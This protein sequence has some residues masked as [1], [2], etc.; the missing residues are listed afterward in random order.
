MWKLP[1]QA[2]K[3]SLAQL[4]EHALCKHTVV[5]E[6]RR[7]W[8]QC[9]W[10]PGPVHACLPP[11]PPFCNEPLLLLFPY[12]SSCGKACKSL[13]RRSWSRL[14]LS[15]QVWCPRYKLPHGKAVEGSESSTLIW[16][17]STLM[18]WNPQRACSAQSTHGPLAIATATRRSPCCHC[19]ALEP[20]STMQESS[21]AS[22]VEAGAWQRILSCTRQPYY[23]IPCC[24]PTPSPAGLSENN[25]AFYPLLHCYP[26]ALP[27]RLRPAHSAHVTKRDGCLFVRSCVSS[28]GSPASAPS[29]RAKRVWSEVHL[30]AKLLAFLNF[31]TVLRMSSS[32]RPGP[33]YV[34]TTSCTSR[35]TLSLETMP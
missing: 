13:A 31:M 22:Q 21:V 8:K 35:H 4:V 1:L 28:R 24:S 23:S 26:P 10:E 12:S 20:R 18:R 32:T 2:T 27:R 16:S 7:S 11:S 14:G 17:A 33:K 5:S 6:V 25:C 30:E 3:A 9:L 15:L 19:L 29:P 34:F